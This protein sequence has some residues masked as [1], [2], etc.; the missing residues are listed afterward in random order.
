MAALIAPQ[1]A[2]IG[3]RPS[4][5]NALR[6]LL[7]ALLL[8]QGLVAQAGEATRA[9]TRI[10]V[11]GASVSGGF[12]DGPL[13]GAEREGD[14]IALYR[15]WQ[16]WAGDRARVSTHAPV[17]MCGMFRDP[18]RIG[19]REIDVAR[20]KRPDVVLAVDFLFWFAYGYVAGD[21]A[22]ARRQ[23]LQEGLSLLD[24]LDVPMVLGDL[25][26]M[27][28]AATRMLRPAQVPSATV[29][30]ALNEQVR[31]FAEERPEVALVPL[32]EMVSELRVTGVTLP[33]S[34]G[35]VKTAPLA[36]LQPDQ[37]H[38]NRLGVAYVAFRLQRA[39]QQRLPPAHP[40]AR[41][42]WSFDDFVEAA[43]AVDQPALSAPA[44]GA[45]GG[46]R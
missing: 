4:M 35:A 45:S 28:G 9:L 2:A 8:L 11:I 17:E 31:A 30:A 13:F 43:G 40:L 36:L 5:S 44:G 33:L 34:R 27:R 12:E 23:R 19:R 46:R 32:S 25:P 7:P 41:R 26:D 14:S 10:H 6:L 20:R 1:P 29:L 18:S 24:E 3:Y 42:A 37:L 16:R 39:V 21:E 38:A 15:V 22:L